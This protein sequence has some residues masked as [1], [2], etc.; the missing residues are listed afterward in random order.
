MKKLTRKKNRNSLNFTL[1]EL[2]VVIAIIAILAA[3]LLPALNKAR[4][5]A[6]AIS[7]VSNLK[8]LGVAQEVYLDD[9]DGI[10][11]IAD[12][13]SAN[14]YL[15]TWA[16]FLLPY[17]NRKLPPSIIDGTYYKD[18]F[19]TGVVLCPSKKEFIDMGLSY[20]MNEN[21]VSNKKAKV[22]EPTICALMADKID[23]AHG[24]FGAETDNNT[25]IFWDDSMG[26]RH[27]NLK[28][29]I[30]FVDGHV[31]GHWE[32]EARSRLNGFPNP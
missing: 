3:M 18:F 30:L 28:T 25:R 16:Y 15:G 1:I 7:C 11:C 5:A 20:G 23:D 29:N 31:A 4:E 24:N 2:L 13:A 10:F 6:K 19:Q 21:L 22:K 27:N 14:A 8:Q 12:G 26:Y 32:M 9:Y 17:L